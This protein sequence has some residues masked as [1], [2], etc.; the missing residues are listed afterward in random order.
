MP[1]FDSH[2]FLLGKSQGSQKCPYRNI[3][4]MS[5]RENSISAIRAQYFIALL[6]RCALQYHNVVIVRNKIWL[7][8][9]NLEANSREI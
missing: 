5:W 6:V 7:K 8:K 2:I 4:S 3:P 9:P 1:G